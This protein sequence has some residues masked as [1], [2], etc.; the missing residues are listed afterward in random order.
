M[1]KRKT[2]IIED[3]STPSGELLDWVNKWI[4]RGIR[5][6]EIIGLMT[7]CAHYLEAECIKAMMEPERAEED[8]EK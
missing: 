6:T 3:K 4:H 7:V 1:S 2:E 8:K 5:R